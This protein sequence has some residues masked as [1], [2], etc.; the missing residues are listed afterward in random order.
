MTLWRA[1]GNVGEQLEGLGLSWSWEGG[2]LASFGLD[3][4]VST[5]GVKLP[6]ET[7]LRGGNASLTLFNTSISQQGEYHCTVS[8][9]TSESET[10]NTTL[11]ILAPPTVRVLRPLVSIGRESVVECEA[12]GFFP[13]PIQFSWLR[14]DIVERILEAMPANHSADGSYRA[15]SQLHLIP[16]PDDAG[17][18]YSCLVNHSALASPLREDF[19]LIFT[20]RP[21]VS[22]SSASVSSGEPQTL[23]CHV[24]DF[25]PEEITIRWLH[26]GTLMANGD[27]TAPRPH[28]T[29]S[30][31]R[32]LTLSPAQR[33]VVGEVQCQVTQP[34]FEPPASDTIVL[35]VPD[36][37]GAKAEM[38]KA[39]KAAVAL[40]I[41]S[42]V[43][44]ILLGFGF[45][46]RKRDE[47][48]KG[49]SVSGIILPTKMV[50][51]RKAVLTCCVE[52]RLVDRVH[53]A[54][55]VNDKP[56]PA[57]SPASEELPSAALSSQDLEAPLLPPAS[58]RG[59]Y[60]LKTQR[61]LQS[62]RRKEQQL[63]SH[64]CF[65][66]DLR[67][68]RG[69]LFK[70]QVSY[71]GKEK[72]VEERVSD[73]VTLLAAPSVSEIRV[74]HS[75]CEGDVVSGTSR[76]HLE[77]E[78]SRFHP[79]LVTFRWFCEGGELSPAQPAAE[80]LPDTEGYFRAVSQCKVPVEELRRP[81]FKVWVTVHHMALKE[82]IT[83]ESRGLVKRP[84]VSDISCSPGQ[85]LTLGC[86]IAGFYPSDLAVSWLRKRGEDEEELEGVVSLWGPMQT[87]PH[88][89]RASAQA[90]LT[91]KGS[92]GG[93]EEIVCRVEHSSLPEPIERQWTHV[94]TGNIG[95]VSVLC[96]P[97]SVSVSVF[98]SLSAV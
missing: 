8:Y 10:T 74:V 36:T 75:D 46:W 79:G 88:T 70:C 71:Q 22:V 21:V 6:E 97:Q 18:N 44:V 82:P 23:Y 11:Y 37:G 35:S 47:K 91:E 52:G 89:Y 3:G 17:H 16:Q 13:P 67:L 55:F 60:R 4:N 30:T 42:L 24:S 34:G 81:G 31:T 28:G 98:I 2:V 95:T 96:A 83:R 94:S 33:E 76:V 25:F 27:P 56:I 58:G 54:W 43:L 41:I 26:N 48:L 9:N 84:E 86:Q 68:H 78:A 32:Y 73:R 90:V 80:P 1:T 92:E 65:R 14:D 64:L 49:L 5:P 51:G 53:A 29:F 87:D 12:E 7:D 69:A 45:S 59:Y 38:S 40:M 93:R 63:L 66:P 62:S 50:V 20:R 61:P 72:V 85:P 39:A 19:T 15:L 57:Y 77:V